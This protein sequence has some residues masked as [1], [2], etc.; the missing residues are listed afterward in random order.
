M[1][2]PVQSDDYPCSLAMC[3]YVTCVDIDYPLAIA[4]WAVITARPGNDYHAH[5]MY[6]YAA[7]QMVVFMH[8]LCSQWRYV[9]RVQVM[10]IPYYV[11]T[12]AASIA[13]CPLCCM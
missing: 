5:T 9:R 12:I 11:L 2:S 1:Q 3:D 6:V 4:I 8:A 13:S 10:I 7:R